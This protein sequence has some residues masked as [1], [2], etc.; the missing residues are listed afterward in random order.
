ML[1]TKQQYKLRKLIGELKG[2]KGRHTELVTVYI[3]AGYDLV[4]IT[5]HLAEEQGTASNIK[6]KT[7]RLNVQDSLDRMIRHLRL[8]PKTPE[9]GLA[10]F[11]GN[12]AS[13]EGKQDIKVWTIEPPVALGIRMYRC[14]QTFVLGPLEDMLHTNE[15]Y[16]LLV[17]DN[18]EATL[19][20]LKGKS[21]QVIRDFGSSVPGKVKVG[22]WS[23]Q[24]YARLREDAAN[25]FYKRIVDVL[26]VEF[27]AI[28]KDLKGILV[29]GPGPTKETFVNGAYIHTEL[30]K[31]IIAVK[32]ISYT[33]EQG[34]HELVDRSQ[35][36]LA[37]AEIAKE[38]KILNEFFTLLATNSDK[39]IYG[40]NDVLKALDYGAVDKLII[41]ES[42]SELDQYE[43]KANVTGTNVFFVSIE[44]KEGVQLRELGGV[45]AILRYAIKDI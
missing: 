2:I 6:D 13:Q 18:R 29:G 24:R 3:P 39:V 10:A 9:N 28:G 12:T 38:K 22:G 42:F 4:K 43:E 11:S 23:Q 35:D 1:D 41:S 5:Q 8:Y 21:I 30:K 15:I 26:N 14:D 19:G 16:G 17:M 7:T 32:D 34:L 36:V 40:K 20:F 37:E 44:T 25:E 27:A 45:G 33:D 31:K